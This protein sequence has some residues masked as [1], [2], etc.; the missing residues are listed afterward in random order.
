MSARR[1]SRRRG[2][3]QGERSEPSDVR[4]ATRPLR[5]AWR[6]RVRLRGPPSGAFDRPSLRET[7][8]ALRS[9][10][11]ALQGQAGRVPA[12]PCA[13]DEG[14]ALRRVRRAS[15]RAREA[16]A[17][18]RREDPIRRVH[19]VRVRRDGD[20]SPEV[21][22]VS[23]A[24][25]GGRT[26]SVRGAHRR[27]A[28]PV[29]RGAGEHA[30]RELRAMPSTSASP[31]RCGPPD[32]GGRGVDHPGAK[33]SRLP[34]E[35]GQGYKSRTPPAPT[36]KGWRP[37]GQRECERYRTPRPRARATCARP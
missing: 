1:G 10:A 9:P 24:R 16:R 2:G 14:P 22:R 34:T 31:V 17:A 37:K 4:A 5:T 21:H 19:L 32:Q 15:P 29:R 6:V 3:R 36:K 30:R 12:L 13:S 11:H 25:R 8:A 27:G 7:T 28:L 23:S 33:R 18:P 35:S 20:R 26:G